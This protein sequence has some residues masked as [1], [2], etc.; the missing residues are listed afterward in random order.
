M[1]G[2]A[3]NERATEWSMTRSVAPGIVCVPPRHPTARGHGTR[4]AGAA[5]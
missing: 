3:R 2:A 4:R 1:M 5:P